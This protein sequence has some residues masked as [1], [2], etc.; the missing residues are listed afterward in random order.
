MSQNFTTINTI[1][2]RY[3][4]AYFT[5]S[6]NSKNLKDICTDVEFLKQ[7]LISNRKLKLMVE[8]T[9][10]PLKT[11]EKLIGFLIKNY[12][13]SEI[14][15]NFLKI[16]V[17]NRRLNALSAIIKNFQKLA[18]ENEGKIKAFITSISKID[19]KQ[20]DLIGKSLEKKYAKKILCELQEDKNILGG[21]IIKIGSQMIDL[22]LITKLKNFEAS[23]DQILEQIN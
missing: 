2:T 10:A 4:K 20:V 6:K 18:L 19:K 23:S 13:F 1:S 14:S 8:N 9:H 15:E 3:A 21:L 16:L 12:K 7:S 5:L 11:Q 22:S 17:K